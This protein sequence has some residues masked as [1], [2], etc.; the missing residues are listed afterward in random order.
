M[1]QALDK[2]FNNTMPYDVPKKRYEGRL[3]SPFYKTGGLEV[4]CL[5][6]GHI[7]HER[8]SRDSDGHSE[9]PQSPPGFLLV[10]CLFIYLFLKTESYFVAKVE[11]EL[12]I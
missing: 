6:Q 7:M 1:C 9:W 11:L 3:S 2:T 4:K 10:Y 12:T 5:A 8:W